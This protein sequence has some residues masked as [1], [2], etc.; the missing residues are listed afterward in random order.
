MFEGATGWLTK[1]MSLNKFEE[2]LLNL[3]YTDKNVSTYNKKF[4]QMRQ[5]ENAWNANMTKVLNLPGLAC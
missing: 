2:I 3:S 4:F 5:M 1:Y